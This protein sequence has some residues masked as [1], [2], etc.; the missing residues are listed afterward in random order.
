MG[1]NCHGMNGGGE[2]EKKKN[3]IGKCDVIPTQ[4]ILLFVLYEWHTV[5]LMP[6]TGLWE[7]INA[8]KNSPFIESTE[9]KILINRVTGW[10]EVHVIFWKFNV[11]KEKK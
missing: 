10:Y 9:K 1:Y 6:M 7:M 3:K 4:F 5:T 2:S 8:F 11:R